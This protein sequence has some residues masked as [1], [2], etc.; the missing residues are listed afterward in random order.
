MEQSKVKVINALWDDIHG[1]FAY[2]IQDPITLKIKRVHYSQLRENIEYI[3]NAHLRED[4]KVELR[5]ID[6]V[7]CGKDY[8]KATGS[9]KS[10]FNDFETFC[11]LNG[12]EDLL[13][14][15]D[16][17][18]NPK[19]IDMISA[20][21]IDTVWWK[22]NK[23]GYE[24][25]TP[26]K[27]RTCTRTNTGCPRCRA[28]AGKGVQLFKGV[29][30][31]E[32]WCTQ[33]SRQDILDSVA[34]DSP[35]K[36]SEISA[37]S[38]RQ[39]LKFICKYCGSEYWTTP[40][41]RTMS[42]GCPHCN[43][44]GVSFPE[45]AIYYAMSELFNSVHHK[46][47]FTYNGHNLEFDIY[48]EDI[49]LAIEFDGAYWHR[50]E[51]VALREEIKNEA[52]R[53]NDIPLLRIKEDEKLRANST[54]DII[55]DNEITCHPG[56]KHIEQTLKLIVAWINKKFNLDYELSD[57]QLETV[58]STAKATIN[59]R[60]VPN[61]VAEVAPEVAARWDYERNGTLRPE[62]VSRGCK[63][64]AWFKCPD[65]GNSYYSF[66]RKQVNGQRCPICAGQKVVPGYNDFQTHA[67]YAMPFWDFEKNG[68]NGI[69]P[70]M[71]SKKSRTRVHWKCPDCGLESYL[72][73]HSFASKHYCTRCGKAIRGDTSTGEYMTDWEKKRF[74]KDI[75]RFKTA[76]GLCSTEHLI[77][78]KNPTQSETNEFYTVD[79][80]IKQMGI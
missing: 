53:I 50:G 80:L 22:C 27:S 29:N 52:C 34:P 43:K 5:K 61:S 62:N 42:N 8:T 39:K 38:S 51:T 31:F 14:E 13:D 33:N 1:V 25:S 28:I 44:S 57:G 41:I 75:R 46:Y 37:K 63:Y 67:P 72:L 19:S 47:R 73:P 12:R 48:I 76:K 10:G 64:K 58:E 68:A 16:T 30:D 74:G 11:R 17:D 9:F 35:I 4:G 59:S 78:P 32:T 3:S 66:I 79:D 20:H 77:Q 24:W 26:I 60:K 45:L 7:Y 6:K 40:Y 23:C 54:P 56:G 71:I 15:Y 69:Y 70:N 65:C 55:S 21:A 36:P 2:T 18:K 49:N